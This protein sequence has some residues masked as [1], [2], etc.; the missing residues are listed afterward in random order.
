MKIVMNI[1]FIISVALAFKYSLRPPLKLTSRKISTGE[2]N[3]ANFFRTAD[4][5]EQLKIC[6]I[7]SQALIEAEKMRME[8]EKIKIEAAMET[9]RMK[10]EIEKMRIESMLKVERDKIKNSIFMALFGVLAVLLFAINLRT[11][12]TG[13]VTDIERFFTS[14]KPFKLIGSALTGISVSTITVNVTNRLMDT[15]I[16]LLQRIGKK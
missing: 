16:F 9:E 12:L 15:I 13:K 14:L 7:N 8:T 11:G 1:L 5:S 3:P 2:W 10:M 4:E 6:K